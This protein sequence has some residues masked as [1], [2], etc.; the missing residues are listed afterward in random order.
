M[1]EFTF[2]HRNRYCFPTKE[3]LIVEDDLLQQ[4]RF[5]AK[6]LS[7]FGHQ[8]SVIATFVPTAMAAFAYIVG[9]RGFSSG[10]GAFAAAL[11]KLIVLDHDLQHGDGAELLK[12][13]SLNG[14]SMPVMTAS[15]LAGNNDRLMDHGANYKFAKDE[16]I[17]G[18]ADDVILECIGDFHRCPA[19]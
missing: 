13:L 17:A 16:I 1:S 12:A 11:P 4:S 7:L 14:F 9:L 6:F 10:Q 18:K 8:S 19:P 3:I 15:G 2:N 5:A